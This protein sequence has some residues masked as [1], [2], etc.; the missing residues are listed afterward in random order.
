MPEVQIHSPSGAFAF[1]IT[2]SQRE[3][4]LRRPVPLPSLGYDGGT[5]TL[6]MPASPSTAVDGTY[7]VPMPCPATIRTDLVESIALLQWKQAG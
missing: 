5:N 2:A 3:G 7:G 6:T 4:R 1:G